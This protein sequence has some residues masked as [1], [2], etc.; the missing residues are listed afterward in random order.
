M[1]SL[2]RSVIGRTDIQLLQNLYLFLL[3]SSNSQLTLVKTSNLRLIVS[4]LQ[5]PFLSI[6]SELDTSQEPLHFFKKL[7]WH[8]ITILIVIM[9]LFVFFSWL[10]CKYLHSDDCLRI[11]QEDCCILRFQYRCY[12]NKESPSAPW[13]SGKCMSGANKVYIWVQIWILNLKE[14]TKKKKKDLWK[15]ISFSQ[16]IST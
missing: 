6:S 9:K 1:L 2:P 15:D 7:P 16:S 12:M 10:V 5:I 8:K 14:R 11:H 4:F 3:Y 13:K